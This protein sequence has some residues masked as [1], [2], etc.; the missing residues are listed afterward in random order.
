MRY[1]LVENGVVTNIIEMDKRNEQFFP[2]AVYTGDR[3]VGMGD[4][5]TEGKFYRDGKEVWR[6]SGEMDGQVLLSKIEA[7]L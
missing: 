6:Q 2:T 3:P 5:Y 7:Y 4:T 1:A